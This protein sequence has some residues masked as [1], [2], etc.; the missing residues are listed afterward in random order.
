[1]S[2]PVDNRTEW[3]LFLKTNDFNP[4][5]TCKIAG[6]QQPLNFHRFRDVKKKALTGGRY[7]RFGGGVGLLRRARYGF[8]NVLNGLVVAG[9]DRV[10][11]RKIEDSQVRF[12]VEGESVY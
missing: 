5:S 10:H 2:T 3:G 7:D 11:A 12:F 8:H 6:V 9:T 4:V 1:M